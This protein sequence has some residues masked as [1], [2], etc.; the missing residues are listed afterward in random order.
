MEVHLDM[1]APRFPSLVVNQT[2]LM[3]HK[4]VLKMLEKGK[5][6]AECKPP[7]CMPTEVQ[8]EWI[9]GHTGQECAFSHQGGKWL[10]G[11]IASVLDEQE[12]GP[13]KAKPDMK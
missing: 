2:T 7:T 12:N 11:I 8:H 13:Q 9:S 3:L 1:F 6:Q 10:P 4:H 5:N